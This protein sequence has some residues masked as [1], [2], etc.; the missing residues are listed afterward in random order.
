MSDAAS[1][2]LNR[3]IRVAVQAGGLAV[4]AEILTRPSLIKTDGT[5]LTY[6]C[7]VR[8]NGLDDLLRNVPIAL[9]ASDLEYADVGSAVTLRRDPD[10][11]KFE[12]IG[13]SKKKPGRR[14]RIPVNIQTTVLGS[15]QDLTISSR[16]LTFGEIGEAAFGNGFGQTPFGAIGIFRGDALT[17]VTL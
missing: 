9:A 15:I 10:T 16:L 3:M 12:V 14:V 7:T 5:N 1:S 4:E 6:A 11:G 2:L 8:V 17:E 13:F